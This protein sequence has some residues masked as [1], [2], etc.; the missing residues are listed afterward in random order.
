MSS[1]VTFS[2]RIGLIA[3]TVGSAVGLGNV[4]RFPAEV[5]SNGGAAFLLVYIICML[6]L[7][8]PVMI[9]EFALGRGTRSDAMGA[10][11]KL[12]PKSGWWGAGVLAI[13]ASYMILC[14]YMV[15]AGWTLEYLIQSVTG[16]L[17]AI[18][19]DSLQNI[20]TGFHNKMESYIASDI[21]PLVNTWILIG[22]NL[23]ILLKG[24]TK[25]IERISNL[26]MPLLFI[27]LLLFAGIALSMPDAAKGLIFFFTPDFSKIT[28]EVVINALGQ[29]F[30]SLSLGMGILITYSAYYPDKTRLGNTAFIV[31]GFDLLV[32]VLMGIIIFPTV[33]GFNISET[34]LRGTTLVFVTLPEIFASMPGTQLWSILF[35][36]L[37]LV[38]ALTS[39]IS[40]AEVSIAW[41]EKFFHKS[42]TAACFI[43][44][45]P[46]FLFSSICSLSFGSLSG[47]TIAGLSI[48]DFLDTVST[49]FMLPI[50]SVLVCIF[51]GWVLKPY[52]LSN[53]LSNH[54]KFN[55]PLSPY[56]YM[57][58]KYCA[59][60]LLL[61]ILIAS[62]F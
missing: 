48:F 6:L 23:F 27:L 28:P 8:I 61:L 45:A 55:Y 33:A 42:R 20:N 47:I 29:S 39:T 32:A 50:V 1:K 62:F 41:V 40:V 19:T 53:E 43:V 38:A 4:W 58:I 25:G 16:D 9:A 34:D 31:A 46:L 2:S 10:F 49:N 22:I 26:L 59:P 35:F 14:F 11:R 52:F 7:G 24:V 44:L 56:I 57:I 37:L 51:I 60:L 21:N 12:A 30:F 17:Y 3:A 36:L 13:I 18:N 54:G 15:V 5:Q